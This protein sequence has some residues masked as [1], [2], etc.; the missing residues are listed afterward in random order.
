MGL[1]PQASGQFALHFDP[2][3]LGLS[4]PEGALIFLASVFGLL[5][6][7]AALYLVGTR[8]LGGRAFV[9]GFLLRTPILGP[10]LRALALTRFCLALR[11]TLETGMPIARAL[12]LSFRA[13]GNAAFAD[14]LDRAVAAVKEGQELTAA[15]TATGLFPEEFRHILSVAEESG[16]LPEVLRQEADHYH[17]EAGRRTAALTTALTVLVWLIVAGFIVFFVFRVFLSYLDLFNQVG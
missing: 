14:R 6:F 13:T 10:C 5:L 9:D 4:G 12:R 2:V 8:L 15:L 3:G 7:F 11:L 16:R 1:I 17:D